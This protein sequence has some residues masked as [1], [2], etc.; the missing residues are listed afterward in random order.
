MNDLNNFGLSEKAMELIFRVFKGF[1]EVEKVIIFGSRAED[2]FK[3]G[4]DIDLVIKGEN[5]DN[6]MAE[7]IR[8][9]LQEGLY[10]PYFFDVLDYKSIKNE[11][12]KSHIDLY[13]VVFYEKR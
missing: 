6:S 5:I 13:G 7:V 10:L 9:L 11:K 8:N 2:N 1:P 4:S 12:L 3:P